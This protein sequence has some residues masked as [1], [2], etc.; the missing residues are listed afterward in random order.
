MGQHL[1]DAIPQHA[2][3]AKAKVERMRDCE[4]ENVTRPVDEDRAVAF[5]RKR[6]SAV[7][8]GTGRFGVM[9]GGV[10]DV[11]AGCLNREHARSKIGPRSSVV[12]AHH[13][14]SP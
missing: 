4:S 5:N 7:E 11:W 14:R 10:V 9:T 12:P 2:S 3:P 1:R 13:E 6:R 8:P